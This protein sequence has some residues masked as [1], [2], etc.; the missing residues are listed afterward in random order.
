MNTENESNLPKTENKNKYSSSSISFNRSRTNNNNNYFKYSFYSLFDINNKN[1]SRSEEKN[2]KSKKKILKRFMENGQKKNNKSI[3][4]E[5]NTIKKLIMPKIQN[6]TIK[7]SQKYKTIIPTQSS[8]YLIKKIN[9]KNRNSSLFNITKSNNNLMDNNNDNNSYLLNSQRNNKIINNNELP[10]LIDKRYFENK[11][12][13]S[14][15]HYDKHFG[16]ELNCPKCQS[17]DIKANYMK[18]KKNESIP[19]INS[20]L[21]STSFNKNIEDYKRDNIILPLNYFGKL[22]LKNYINYKNNSNL[23][24]SKMQRNNNVMRIKKINIT[25]YS[26]K[27]LRNY[28]TSLMAI[29]DY[30]NIK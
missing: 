8:R 11:N 12:E 26:D 2:H 28:R 16:N 24:L 21:G 27:I 23:I 6:N 1:N 14:H 5:K 22:Y 29:K 3:E 30:F 9:S 4:N 25:K 15:Y 10:D 7:H 20:H 18:E 13:Y 17:M 19:N